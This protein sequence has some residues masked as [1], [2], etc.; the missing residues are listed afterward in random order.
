MVSS[1]KM[2]AVFC[3][4]IQVFTVYL[5]KSFV[6]GKSVKTTERQVCNVISSVD[7]PLATINSCRRSNK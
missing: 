7:A 4:K 2:A 1:G 6:F 3:I 5:K